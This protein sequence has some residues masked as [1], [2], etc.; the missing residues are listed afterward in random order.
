MEAL[1]T[2][3][4]RAEPSL[5]LLLFV[6]KRPSSVEKIRQ[7]RSRLKELAADYPF[8]LQVVDVGE[9]PHLAEHFRLIATPAIIKIYPEPRQTL[10]GSNLIAQ[11][12]SWWSRWKQSAQESRISLG[13][14]SPLPM[15][16][17][18]LPVPNSVTYS[19]ELI[20]LSDEIFRLNQE[21][22]EL[23]EQL[24]F[25]DR[26]IAM[27]AHD[28]RN[29]L[30][31]VSIALETL[32][33][34][35]SMR[36]IYAESRLTPETMS[37]LIKHARTQA[38]TI[39]RLIT[40]TLHAANSTGGKLNVQPRKFDLGKLCLGLVDDFQTKLQIKAQSI[41]T[42]IPSDLPAVYADPDRVR[43]VL[44]NLLDNAVKYTPNGS[45]IQVS[46]L[47]RTTQKVQVSICDDGPGIP[48]ENRDRIFEDSYRLERDTT[49]D[50]YG[51]GL[52]VCQRIV[53]AHY[54]QIWVDSELGAGSC[55]HFTLP[56]YR[57]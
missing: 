29:P 13:S 8:D 41:S 9:Q 14:T 2:P 30:T 36:E 33:L 27:L 52:A 19:A 37:Q 28:L 55:F 53:R 47:H 34:G 35:S 5:Q 49:Q 7:I 43:Q 51:I 11:I 40:D 3:P 57:P 15:A 12:D 16:I 45:H 44:V 24:R 38:K 21:K 18:S 20:R 46:A 22:E 48:A 50:G 32:E 26:L 10:A 39:D 42:D 54:G 25:K 4:D 17:E 23:Q 6:D 31:A 56:V 1:S